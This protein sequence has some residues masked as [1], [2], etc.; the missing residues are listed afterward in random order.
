MGI[1]EMKMERKME[2]TTYGD[3]GDEV[4]R[5]TDSIERKTVLTTSD[6]IMHAGSMGTRKKAMTMRKQE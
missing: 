4:R 2:M 5:R 6:M 1:E 3:K